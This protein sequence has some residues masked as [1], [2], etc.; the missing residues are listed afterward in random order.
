MNK[1]YFTAL[2][3]A[4]AAFVSSAAAADAVALE[5]ENFQRLPN[6]ATEIVLKFTN[7]TSSKLS[8]ISADCAFLDADGKALTVLPIVAQ[9]VAPGE[10]AYGNTFSPRHVVGI[11][12]A[13][14]RLK[15][16]DD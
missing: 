11:E 10:A 13:Q 4:A 14:C 7:N 9:N 1:L 16:Y 2:A 3:A 12:K 6:G 5:Y 8:L 15:Y